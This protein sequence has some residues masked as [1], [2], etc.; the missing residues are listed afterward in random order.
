MS[1]V[2]LPTTC[3]DHAIG[4]QT[5][6][7]AEENNARIKEHLAVRHALGNGQFNTSSFINPLSAV[8]RHNDTLIARSVLQCFIDNTSAVPTLLTRLSGP[9]FGVLNYIRRAAG[10]WQLFLQAPFEFGAVA[11][12]SASSTVDYAVRTYRI[13]DP[14]YGPSLIVSTWAI[15]AGSW[16]LTDL[17]FDLALWMRR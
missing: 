6:Q 4:I 10:Q 17:P 11:T 3:Q 13:T 8:G 14:N 9:A 1:Y 15:D 2:K 5:V 7:Q 12:M 16:A